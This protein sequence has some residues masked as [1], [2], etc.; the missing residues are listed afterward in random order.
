MP[1]RLIHDEDGVGVIGNMAGYLDQM[2]VHGMRIAPWHDEGCRLAKFRAD[3]TE[4]ISGP[5]ALIMRS[6]WPCASFGPAPGDLVLLADAG[7][8][9]EP[10]FYSP[11]AAPAAIAPT[12]AAKFF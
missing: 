11:L 7:F 3:R 6:R 12:A 10:N 4:D 8:I 1:A 5:C 2:L 9:L